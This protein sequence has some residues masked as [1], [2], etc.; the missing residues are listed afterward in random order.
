M[1][2]TPKSP[3]DAAELTSEKRVSFTLD[4]GKLVETVVS[5]TGLF[6][7][8]TQGESQP[9]NSITCGDKKFEPHLGLKAF[10]QEKVVQFPASP[11]N[12]V[13]TVRL[14]GEMSQFIRR[15]ADLPAD[16]LDVV[17]LY[18]LMTWVYDRFT[19]VPYLRFLGE[20]G[21]GKTRIL[22][23]SSAI[24]YK[25]PSLAGPLPAQRSFAPSISSG[26]R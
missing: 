11:A 8:W 23:V 22:Q 3:A 4:N 12:Y 13:D 20:P 10:W 7:F 18:V 14:L 21:T 5:S 19:A 2:S 9:E 17:C 26:G 24:C 15:Y 1:S 16:W 25:A 6:S